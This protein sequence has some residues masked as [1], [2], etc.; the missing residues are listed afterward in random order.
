[1]SSWITTAHRRM[2]SPREY[3]AVTAGTAV[4]S[5]AVRLTGR[6]RPSGYDPAV[7]AGIAVVSF[8]A[9]LTGRE[10]IS[11]LR[12]PITV[13][14]LDPISIHCL[15]VHLLARRLRNTGRQGH[16]DTDVDGSAANVGGGDH[17]RRSR[18]CLPAR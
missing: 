15:D 6:D 8:A 12:D 7:T 14:V 10:P 4:V 1:M 13:H 9:R 18:E 2:Q 3:Q 16:Q 5:I 17:N 11:V